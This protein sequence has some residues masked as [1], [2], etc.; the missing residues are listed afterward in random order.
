[1][2]SSGSGLYTNLRKIIGIIDQLRDI[3]LQKYISL[4]RIAVLGTQ[5]SGKSSLLEMIVGIDFLP[6]GDGVV[7]R[8][9]LELRLVH[10]P[11]LKE[12]YGMFEQAKGV[13]F[14]DFN[15]VRD[16]I[17]ALTDEV[18]GK[19]KGII[20]DPII[21]T[22]YAESCPDLTVIDLP[23]IT[24]IPLANSDQPKDI[25]RITKDM[26]LRYVKDPRTIILCVVPANADISTSDA[27]QIARNIDPKGLRT[28]GVI[29]KIDI[30]DR[31]TNAKSML[32]G[33]DIPLKLGY[34]GVRGRSNQD[35]KDGI[36]V[37]KGLED[38]RKFFASH[39]VYS[40]MPNGYTGTDALTQKLTKVLY[41]HIRTYLPDIYKEI[42]AKM[43]ECEDRLKDLGTPLPQTAGEKL[44]VLW[45]MTTS[46]CENFKNQIRGKYDMKHFQ[47]KTE[48]SGAAKIRSMFNDV[49][50]DYTPGN[51]YR[52][53][54]TY[55]DRD[56]QKAIFLHEGD[57]IPG[58]PSIDAFLSLLQPQLDKLKEPALDLVNSVYA[59]LEEVAIALIGKLFYRFPM[60]IDEFQDMVVKYMQLEKDN[61]RSIV[62]NIV[63]AEQGYLF[64][65]DM[66]YITNRTSI[67]SKDKPQ[68]TD[69]D[70][71]LIGELRNR[72]DSYFALVLRNVRDSVPKAVGHF[73]VRATQDNLQFSLY[74]HINKSKTLMDLLNEPAN[75]TMERETMQKTL[76]VLSKA[77]RLLKKDPDLASAFAS[78]GERD[79]DEEEV[80]KPQQ[81]TKAQPQPDNR[82]STNSMNSTNN[83]N[84]TK[85]TVTEPTKSTNQSFLD[86]SDQKQLQNNSNLTVQQG[87]NAGGIN[88]T[89][90]SPMQGVKNPAP[91]N[92]LFGNAPTN[93]LFGNNV[94]NN[95]NMASQP[96]AAGTNNPFPGT[97]GG[98]GTGGANNPFMKKP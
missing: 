60:L 96:K 3:G 70:K 5:S 66:D 48:L 57:S 71:I 67:V 43:H 72:I 51:K 82:S 34:V 39:P 37:K 93:S 10:T 69:P 68:T 15:K 62:E 21:L 25:E 13:K 44:H 35:I 27:L 4:P 17:N 31:G 97:T 30:M 52:A 42:V 85:V 73:L 28:I 41:A 77:A 55:S 7:T 36:S 9:P 45:E 58:F 76:D 33:T 11:G 24:R 91:S 80:S 20:D 6:R 38:E 65:N 56:I 8:R 54:A 59:Y 74:N 46:F 90:G 63:D 61:A 98:A 79:N 78:K 32:L 18:A 87:G 49:Y 88:P 95:Q 84:T 53:T 19:N 94:P 16:K 86:F 29:T 40:T 1:M 14:T 75:V 47:V 22:V 26:A 83:T 50:E 89:Q 81:N 92:S 23:G 64:T 2:D 12:P